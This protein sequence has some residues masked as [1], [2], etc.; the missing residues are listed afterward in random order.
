MVHKL[1]LYSLQSGSIDI[2]PAANGEPL[3]QFNCSCS[4]AL[5][6]CKA[7]CC[8]ARP[9]YNILVPDD[10]PDLNSVQHPYSDSL[11]VL[12]SNG[13]CCSYL[14]SENRCTIHD[15]KPEYCK[16]W[17]C[18]PGGVGENIIN[19]ANGWIL[20][21]SELTQQNEAFSNK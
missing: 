17:H 8:K 5:P 13:N 19:R 6:F 21:I 7:M 14:S 2:V 1:T 3:L 11:K 16:G 18:S 9:L 10:R 20:R 12:S 4:D 15:K